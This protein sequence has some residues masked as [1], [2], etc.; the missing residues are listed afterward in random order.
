[1]S[2]I[3]LALDQAMKISGFAI[4]K[5]DKLIDYGTFSIP[6]AKPIE[7]RLQLFIKELNNLMN[8]HNVS[9]V[10]FEDIQLQNGNAETYKKLAYIQAACMIWCYNNNLKYTILSPSHWRSV[11]KKEYNFAFGRAREEQ[12]KKAIEFCKEYMNVEV[13]SD[14]ADAILIGKAGLIEKGVRQSAF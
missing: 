3:Y 6:S 9:E 1:M 11:L 12:K 5:E 14:A 10:F 8:K 7:Q 4:Y 2:N 13:E